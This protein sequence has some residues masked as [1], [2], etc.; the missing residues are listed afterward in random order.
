VR[1]KFSDLFDGRGSDALAY[2]A[3]GARHAGEEIE[4]AGWL[5]VAHDG[6]GS[7]MLVEQPGAC[8]D[9]SP[10]PVAAIALPGFKAAAAGAVKL[11]GRLAYGFA[12][13]EG[14]ASFLRLE[15]ARI[16]WGFE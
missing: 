7:V 2:S 8:P 13:H 10:A 6:S 3:R 11:K 1:L 14:R 5:S 9:C 16:S 12:V 4:I 15:H